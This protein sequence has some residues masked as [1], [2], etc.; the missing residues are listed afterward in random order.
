MYDDEYIDPEGLLPDRRKKVRD[1]IDKL[2]F[3]EDFNFDEPVSKKPT[4]EDDDSFSLASSLIRKNKDDVEESK[5]AAE[6]EQESDLDEWMSGLQ[7]IGRVIKPKVAKKGKGNPFDI[8]N[9]KKKKKKKKKEGEPTDFAKEFETEKILYKNLL[10]DQKNFTDTLQRAYNELMSKKSSNRGLSKTA[11]ELMN[12]ITASRNLSV[13]I[14]DKIVSLKKNV[15]DLSM[16][17]R[18]EFG[19]AK[20]A[21]DGSLMT[22]YASKLMREISNERGKIMGTELGGDIAEYSDADDLFSDIE[23]GLGDILDD[24]P[25]DVEK[26]LSNEGKKPVIYACINRSNYADFYF[27]ARSSIDDSVLEDY[28]LP[29]ANSLNVN[30]STGYATDTFGTKYE[31]SWF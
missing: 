7:E 13:Q 5:S 4:V 23:T 6:K 16:K 30:E 26:Y 1:E 19:D 2:S 3:D 20:N 17:E 21:E 28:P 15:F 31:I 14:T 10:S 18:K 8:G 12:S 25:D 22:D 11:T 29:E 9:S 24:R 27:E